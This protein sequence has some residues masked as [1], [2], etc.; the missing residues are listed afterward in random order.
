LPGDR[1][2]DRTLGADDLWVEGDLAAASTDSRSFGPVRTDHVKAKL[3]LIY[4]PKARR[5]LVR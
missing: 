2:Q 5:G 1:I 3:V 4:W